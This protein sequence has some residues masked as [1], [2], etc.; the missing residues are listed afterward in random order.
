MSTL[1]LDP[2]LYKPVIDAALKEDLGL[3]GD[4]TTL[5]T[6]PAS[7]RLEARFVARE[8]G[9][10][11]GLAVAL[12]VFGALD[13]SVEKT[14]LRE[15]GAMLQ[16]GETIAVLTGP[17]RPIL[18]GERTALNILTRL[19]GIATATHRAV[20]AVRPH[21][22]AIACTRK[23]APGLRAL[24]K[25]AV[26]VGGGSNHRF[27]LFDGVLIKD[28]HIVAAGGLRPAIEGAKAGLGH[29]M[30]LEVE[31]DTLEQ[32]ADVLDIGVDA[33]LLDNMS[34]GEIEKAVRLADG[35]VMLEAS[36]GIRPDTV[37]DYAAA[38][39]DVVSLGWL[40]HSTV[41]LDIGLDT[42][43]MERPA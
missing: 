40:T 32:L 19:S 26:R 1:P 23:T 35:R 2:R 12:E 38:G 37:A 39:V 29:M 17:A 6:V 43:R 33:V 28:N 31:V 34:P 11:A 9:C 16:P 7:A 10:L 36:G 4:V 41:G 18:T 24:E 22:T 14:V 3:A 27:G 13:P 20:D 5:S 30:K 21:K 25:Y 42:E 15:D 8:A